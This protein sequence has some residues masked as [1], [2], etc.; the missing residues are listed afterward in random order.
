MSLLLILWY[1]MRYSVLAGTM[2][3]ELLGPVGSSERYEQNR[4]H[5]KGHSRRQTIRTALRNKEESP[6]SSETPA[7]PRPSDK[8]EAEVQQERHFK[9]HNGS[10]G[11]AYDRIFGPFIKGASKL[12]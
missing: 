10:T 11:H 6:Q 1:P 9:I 3:D 4:G 8:V 12:R 5:Q 7:L 2:M